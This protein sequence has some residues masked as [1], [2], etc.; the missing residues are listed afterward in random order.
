MRI[1][2]Y[3][4]DAFAT[5]VFKGNP[6]AVCLLE[7][8]PEEEL[9]QSIAA[10]NNLSE[11]AFLVA[12]GAR[13]ALR[14]F[15]PVA[16]V[17]LCGHATLAAAHVLFRHSGWDK[18]SLR[19]AT[20]SGELTVRR[21]GAGYLMD[22]PAQEVAPCPLPAPLVAGLGRRPVELYASEDYLAVF[23]SEEEVRAVAPN[24][25]RLSELGLRG[26]I[27]TAPGREVDFVSRFFAPK[28]GIPEDPVTGSAHC[29]LAPYWAKRLEKKVLQAAQLSRRAGRID[30]E[31]QGDRVV[32]AGTAVTFMKAEIILET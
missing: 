10:K 17:P 16:E 26:V 23:E 22:F 11:T 12:A 6:A 4:V 18:E 28:L 13:H 25:E 5:R 7:S 1:T 8:W 20:L 14:W 3:Q 24:F 9:L 32:L 31:V 19:F 21:A 15:T 27:V 29:A 2:Q 30:C